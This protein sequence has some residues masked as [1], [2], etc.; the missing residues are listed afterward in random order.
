MEI[1][2]A[3]MCSVGMWVLSPCSMDYGAK[4]L[5]LASPE[6]HN[7]LSPDQTETLKYQNGRIYKLSKNDWVMQLF[8][9]SEKIT[10][11]SRFGSPCT[12]LM[13]TMVVVVLGNIQ[14]YLRG[15][16]QTI[17]G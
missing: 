3:W 11:H 10:C 8:V 13:M 4:T 15:K 5:F 16:Y 9:I 7:F 12:K 1:G 14:I 2:G 6:M 17:R